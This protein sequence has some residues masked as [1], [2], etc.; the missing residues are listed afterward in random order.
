MSTMECL[1]KMADLNNIL[2]VAPLF[3]EYRQWYGMSADLSGA[4]S[5]LMQRT[6]AS[7]SVV[8][9]AET[10]DV[11]VGFV[12]L[13]PLF[14]SISLESIWVLNDL[15]VAVDFRGKGIGT[16]LLNAATEFARET[17]AIRMELETAS[18]NQTAQRFYEA[19]GWQKE[20]EMLA[21]RLTLQESEERTR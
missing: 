1:L 13:Y 8:L 3:D 11:V 20:T 16:M 6:Q 2:R 17:G 15:F 7:E 10:D 21:Y 4:R 12:Q 9:F 14:S 18:T 19:H 5:F